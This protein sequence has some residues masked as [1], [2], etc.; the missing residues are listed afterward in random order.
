L[1]RHDSFKSEECMFS[2]AAIRLKRITENKSPMN[3]KIP[4]VIPATPRVFKELLNLSNS[5][6][7][8]D[9]LVPRDSVQ[10]IFPPRGTA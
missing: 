6:S 2:L 4:M 5:I 10:V 7:R 8:H 9:D 1:I 3:S